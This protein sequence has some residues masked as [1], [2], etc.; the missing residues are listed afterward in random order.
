MQST[1]DSFFFF[2]ISS[3]TYLPTT[4]PL[5]KTY[6]TACSSESKEGFCDKVDTTC[7]ALNTC[8]TCDTFGGMGGTCVGIA[9]YPNATGE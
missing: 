3:N 7:S 5:P 6:Y 4:Y 1:N 9:S 8:R 2:S